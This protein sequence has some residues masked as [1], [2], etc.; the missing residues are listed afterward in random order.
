MWKKSE[1]DQQPV[2]EAPPRVPSE[3]PPARPRAREGA[4]IGPSIAIHGDVTGE[5]D[6]IVQGRV[7]GTVKLLQNNVTVGKDGRIKANVHARVIVVEGAMEG[8][9][10]GDE[11]VVVRRSGQVQGNIVAPRVTLEDGCRFR[12]SIEMEVQPEARPEGTAEARPAGRAG[13]DATTVQGFRPAAVQ[14]AKEPATAAKPGGR[15]QK[16]SG[17]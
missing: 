5:E 8:D 2:D 15:D 13:A 12:G 7:E 10:R 3:P 16:A 14:G 9:L 17:S 1:P 6:L 4:T 11:Q